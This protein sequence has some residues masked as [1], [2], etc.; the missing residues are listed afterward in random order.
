MAETACDAPILLISGPSAALDLEVGLDDDLDAE[1]I[2]AFAIDRLT[3]PDPGLLPGFAASR[4]ADCSWAMQAAEFHASRIDPR[5]SLTARGPLL[6]IIETE[7]ER[8]ATIDRERADFFGG[9]GP[10]IEF[11][12]DDLAD[13]RFH[14]YSGESAE[15]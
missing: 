13:L 12:T 4:R 8:I 15:D 14:P 11:T 3:P 7:S 1:S 9:A 6:V 5:F 10:A 2:L